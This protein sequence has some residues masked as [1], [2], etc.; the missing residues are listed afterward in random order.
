MDSCIR[1]FAAFTHILFGMDF[2]SDYTISYF[3]QSKI[4]SGGR[5]A[6]SESFSGFQDECSAISGECSGLSECCSGVSGRSSGVSDGRS[7]ISERRSGISEGR[8]AISE[9]RSCFG[10]AI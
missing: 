2:L 10:K 8:S 1:F 5:S 6:I 3:F 9:R 4:V 7:A